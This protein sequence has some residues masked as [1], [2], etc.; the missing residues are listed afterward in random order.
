MPAVHLTKNQ[1]ERVKSLVSAFF[2]RGKKSPK[3]EPQFLLML[4]MV[5]RMIDDSTLF[6]PIESEIVVY[7]LDCYFSVFEENDVDPLAEQ[8]YAKLTGHW[9]EQF[10]SP[11]YDRILVNSDTVGYKAVKSSRSTTLGF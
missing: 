2:E 9:S 7:L 8:A 5:L 10:D 4:Q 11:W 1:T 6:E 3:M